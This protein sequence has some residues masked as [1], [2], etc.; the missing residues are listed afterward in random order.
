MWICIKKIRPY[1]TFSG[2]RGA[3]FVSCGFAGFP[4]VCLAEYPRA[5]G[6]KEENNPGWQQAGPPHAR[7]G[8]LHQAHQLGYAAGVPE[9]MLRERQ[10]V[11]WRHYGPIRR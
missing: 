5:A 1:F 7:P 6:Q 3:N 2:Q 9:K 8:P 4:R 10:P 11:R